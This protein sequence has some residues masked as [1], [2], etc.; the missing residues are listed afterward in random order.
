MKSTFYINLRKVKSSTD[1]HP[2]LYLKGG[3][4]YI[5]YKHLPGPIKLRDGGRRFQCTNMIGVILDFK[6]YGVFLF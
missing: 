4:R 3:E 1:L 5:T 2:S 6:T